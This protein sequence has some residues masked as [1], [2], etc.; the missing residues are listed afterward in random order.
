MKRTVAVKFP[1]D[2]VTIPR[3]SVS[4]TATH[5]LLTPQSFVQLRSDRDVRLRVTTGAGEFT[6][7][8]ET[9]VTADVTVEFMVV[10][11]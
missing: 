4:V 5:A 7:H 6:V 10:R 8:A 9:P 11:Q 2:R 3:G 1:I